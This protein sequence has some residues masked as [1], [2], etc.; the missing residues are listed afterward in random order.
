MKRSPGHRLHTT[1]LEILRPLRLEP[2]LPSWMMEKLSQLEEVQRVLQMAKWLSTPRRKQVLSLV[3]YPRLCPLRN[4]LVNLAVFQAL[5]L[6][7]FRQMP[8]AVFLVLPH[9]PFRL[10]NPLLFPV[11]IPVV[12]PVL[13]RRLFLLPHLVFRSN[14]PVNHLILE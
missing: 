6:H 13:S 7:Q 14:L 8:P 9:R 2:A 5:S 3:L 4:H 10:R 12:F 11:V 1:L